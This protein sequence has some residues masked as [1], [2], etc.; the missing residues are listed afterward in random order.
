LLS[1]SLV[2]G[3]YLSFAGIWG[4]KTKQFRKGEHAV[5]ADEVCGDYYYM[6]DTI[7]LFQR[8]RLLTII[9]LILI[10]NNFIFY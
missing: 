8:N 1:A 6:T 5:F 3:G 7:I 9:L 4:I 2:E 10:I